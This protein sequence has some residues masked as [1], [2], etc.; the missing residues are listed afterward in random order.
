MISLI[1]NIRQTR[2]RTV[3][4]FCAVLSACNSESSDS[5]SQTDDSDSSQ[6]IG[7]MLNTSDSLNG[8]TLFAPMKNSTTYLIDNCG[9]LVQSW[10]SDYTTKAVYLLKNGNLLHTATLTDVENDEFQEGGGQTGRLEI[11][12]PDGELEWY[13]EV[14]SDTEFMHHDVEYVESTGTVFA[15]IWEKH[16]AT[17][18]LAAGYSGGHALWSEKIIEIDPTVDSA[19]DAVIWE[20]DAWDHLVQDYDAS[21]ENYAVIADNPGLVDINY[22]SGDTEYPAD[23]L[24]INAIDY[25]TD[26]DQLV[27]SVRYLS[28][29]WIIDHST[30]TAEAASHEGGDQGVGGDI[31]YRW[32]NPQVYDMGNG[33][34]QK[35]FLQHA[36][37]WIDDG[38]P[39]AGKIIVFNNQAGY[40]QVIDYST[41]NIIDTGVDTSS[42]A[43]TLN[44]GGTYGPDDFSWTYAADNKTNFY[45]SYISGASQLSNGNVIITEGDSGT[46]FEVTE[47]GETVW[48]YVNPVDSSG[49]MTQGTT[50]E[51]NDVFRAYRY[52]TDYDGLAYYSLNSSGTIESGTSSTTC[53]LY[54]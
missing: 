5:S 54:Y 22:S 43:Y 38:D 25:N 41:V 3:C 19:D 17:E 49:I 35:L 13:Y 14:N 26:Y 47:D 46:L 1:P 50:S 53:T 4:I 24:H 28:E 7:I 34:D 10:A 2:L 15:L 11:Y 29:F 21:R 9:D 51:T 42:G 37:T 27:V 52:E 12:N 18:A 48:K 39:D 40:N 6:T 32:G 45:S 20:W 8:Y 16:T 36:V 33:S 44:D 31:L 23:W 30:T